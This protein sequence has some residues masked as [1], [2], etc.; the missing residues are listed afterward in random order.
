MNPTSSKFDWKLVRQ[1][2]VA[3]IWVSAV[4]VLGQMLT[5]LGPWYQ[6][7]KQPEWK[8]PD[9]AFGVIWT[10]IF[11]L[12]VISGVTAWRRATHPS[13]HALIITLF[14]IN[15]ILHVL[16]STLFFAAKRP[17]WALIELR[18]F[19]GVHRGPIIAAFLEDFSICEPDPFAVL[20]LGHNGWVFELRQYRTQRT[21]W[22]CAGIG[23]HV[24]VCA[25]CRQ[26]RSPRGGP[27]NDPGLLIPV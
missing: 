14:G 18:I 22:R 12:I 6:N 10:S 20:G 25:K 4:S 9:W 13:Q 5:D 19:V 8:P 21:I 23:A 17:D 7:L 1:I 26:R 15:S 3:V 11:V 24:N 2:A 16:W 27:G